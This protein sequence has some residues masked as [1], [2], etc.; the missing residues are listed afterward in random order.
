MPDTTLRVN[1]IAN[2]SALNREITNSERKIDRL[3]GQIARARAAGTDERGIRRTLR[4]ERRIL[5][6]LQAQR[7]AIDEKTSIV[8]QG[9]RAARRAT[10]AEERIARTQETLSRRLDRDFRSRLGRSASLQRNLRDAGPLGLAGAGFGLLQGGIAGAL[11]TAGVGAGVATGVGAAAAGGVAL[12]ALPAI[13]GAVGTSSAIAAEEVGA[14]RRSL[15]A[16]GEEEGF[17]PEVQLSRFQTALRGTITEADALRKLISIERLG[18][19]LLSDNVDTFVADIKNIAVATGREFDD[20]FESIRRFITRGTFDRV[21]D[22]LPGLDRS[23]IQQIVRDFDGLEQ[24]ALLAQ[25]ALE[26]VGE[27]S[28]QL[29]DQFESGG[30]KAQDALDNLKRSLDDLQLDFGQTVGDLSVRLLGDLTNIVESVNDQ[31][32]TFAKIYNQLNVLGRAGRYLGPI[33]AAFSYPDIP[34]NALVTGQ[35][36][37]SFARVAGLSQEQ[38]AA[39]PETSRDFNTAQYFRALQGLDEN[40]LREIV[41]SNSGNADIRLLLQRVIDYRDDSIADVRAQIITPEGRRE[42]GA[43]TNEQI[44]RVAE[45]LVAAIDAAARRLE[46]RRVEGPEPLSAEVQALLNRV[47]SIAEGDLAV[48]RPTGEEFFG[49][50]F[51]GVDFGFQLGVSRGISALPPD[52]RRALRAPTELPAVPQPTFRETVEPAAFAVG[53]G[54]Q[55]REAAGIDDTTFRDAVGVSREL[56]DSIVFLSETM[57]SATSQMIFNA[58]SIEDVFRGLLQELYQQAAPNFFQTALTSLGIGGLTRGG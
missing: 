28:E 7:R 14:L 47:S 24:T 55:L 11:G 27:T 41:A 52:L 5:E 56:S 2:F 43:F 37:R 31:I 39:V 58:R 23:R 51:T 32:I 42:A 34:V 15:A 3:S 13:L 20:V 29:G 26:A 53:F 57:T 33:G 9:R 12:A 25:I 46:A 40:I 10:R 36:R 49:R 54:P 21:Q 18:I 35:E 48:A 30:N 38:R 19:P 44:R 50:D 4:E 17:V 8:Q 1:A 22:F 6:G 45:A 16:I